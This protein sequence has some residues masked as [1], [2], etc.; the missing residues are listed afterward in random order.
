[1]IGIDI[2]P[3]QPPKGV[4]TIQGNF[5]SQAVQD[6]VKEFLLNPNNGKLRQQR[7]LSEDDGDGISEEELEEQ[8]TSIIDSLHNEEA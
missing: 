7:M 1:M 8:N 5:L 3:A 6:S 2:I 4:S